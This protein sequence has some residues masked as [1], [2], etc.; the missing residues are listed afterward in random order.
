[1]E[2]IVIFIGSLFI[3]AVVGNQAIKYGGN[4]YFGLDSSNVFHCLGAGFKIMIEVFILMSSFILF[5]WAVMEV[6]K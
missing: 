5:A 4:E 6:S 3:T 2:Y 1:M